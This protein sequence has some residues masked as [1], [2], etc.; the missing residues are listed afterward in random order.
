VDHMSASDVTFVVDFLLAA[1]LAL[2]FA[3]GRPRVWYRDRLGWVIFSYAVATVAL[4]SLIV[5][6]VV[7][8]QR[9]GEPARFF[10]GAALGAALLAKLRAVYLERRRGRMP[11]TRPYS[12]LKEGSDKARH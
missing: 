12:E 5:Y 1:A 7:F 10:V 8:G 6:G 9:V 3:V 4:L 11:G 2:Y